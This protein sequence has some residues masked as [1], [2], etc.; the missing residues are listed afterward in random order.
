MEK[1]RGKIIKRGIQLTK[2]IHKNRIKIIYTFIKMEQLDNLPSQN[3]TVDFKFFSFSHS[4]PSFF[5]E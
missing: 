4:F 1:E 3:K 5:L 2:I